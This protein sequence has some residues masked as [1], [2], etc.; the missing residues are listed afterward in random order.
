[1]RSYNTSGSPRAVARGRIPQVAACGIHP[2]C[3]LPRTSLKL[4]TLFGHCRYP[5][6]QCAVRGRRCMVMGGIGTGGIVWWRTS[7]LGCEKLASRAA[8]RMMKAA[9][10]RGPALWP[11]SRAFLRQRRRWRVRLRMLWRRSWLPPRCIV[12]GA[13]LIR[14]AGSCSRG[15]MTTHRTCTMILCPRKLVTGARR[16]HP[17]QRLG[18]WTSGRGCP[19][20][21]SR[22]RRCCS[23]TRQPSTRARAQGALQQ[24]RASRPAGKS[25]AGGTFWRIAQRLAAEQMAGLAAGI[26]RS[27]WWEE[28]CFS[29]A[30]AR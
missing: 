7:S 11:I 19:S 13:A 30:M 27:G 24:S 1:M 5:P 25:S 8:V 20:S 17:G 6:T 2:F 9:L 26:T 22:R 21:L 15:P 3:A 14:A 29:S 10:S 4:A 12:S 18:T 16:L 23:A 28:R